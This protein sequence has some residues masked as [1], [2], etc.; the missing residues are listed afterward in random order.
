M[1]EIRQL[2][3]ALGAQVSGVSLGE[4]DDAQFDQVHSAFL[5][6]SVLV[7]PGQEITPGEQVAFTEKFG[8][9]RPHPLGTRVHREGFPQVLVLE[10]KPGRPGAR[11]DFWHSDISF[12]PEPPRASILYAIRITEGVGDTLFASMYSAYD[13]LSSDMKTKLDG[14]T[15]FHSSEK[16]AQRAADSEGTDARP[17]ESIPDPAE[18]PVVREH[19]E[20]GRPALY[21]NPYFTTHFSGMSREESRPLI[22]ELTS[23]A[24]VDSNVFRHRWRQGDVVMWDNRCAMH[25]AEYDYDDN[26]ARL[27]NRT[28]AG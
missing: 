19:S 22:E 24:T 20:T 1:I 26:Q 12:V 15:A 17:I 18:H 21:V 3:P 25:Y 2:H 5:S 11:N 10:N 28:T 4:L 27:M 16:L 7:F 6:Y 8:P 9:A 23:L 14:L 13:G